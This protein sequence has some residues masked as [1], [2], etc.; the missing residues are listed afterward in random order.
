MNGAIKGMQEGTDAPAA[1]VPPSPRA[2]RRPAAFS[3]FLGDRPTATAILLCA[4]AAAALDGLQLSRPGY[5]LGRTA[6]IAVYLGSAVRLIHG[7]APYRDF[8][9]VQPPG[10]TLLLSP[11][12]LLSDLV[13]TRGALTAVRLGAILVAVANVIL[14][15]RLVRHRGPLLSLVA[16]AVMAVYPAEL[17]ALNAGLLEPLVDLFCLLGAVIIFEEGSCTLSR[18]RW[19]IGGAAVGFAAAVKLPALFPALVL[20]VM[21]LPAP[22]RRLL[23][24]AAGGV[25]GF[26]VPT[27]AFIAAAPGSF[28]RDV[29]LSQLGRSAGRA[30]VAVRLGWMALNGDRGVGAIAAAL[31]VLAVIVLGM[32]VRGR[33][34]DA[35]ERFAIASAALIA[36]AQFVPAQYFPQYAAL[37]GPYLAITLGVAADRLAARARRPRWDLR[38]V[39]VILVFLFGASAFEV[40]GSSVSDPAAAIDAVVPPGGCSISS[41]PIVLVISD[42]FVS[43]SPGCTAMVDSFGTKLAFADDPSAGVADYRAAITHADYLVLG[44]PAAAWL[45]GAYAPL[46]AYV[47][48]DFHLVRSGPEWIYI[49]DGSPVA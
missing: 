11:A 9:L 10:S 43:S 34:R 2:A 32:A 18:R 27:I 42:R 7:A 8:V 26:G 25:A 15:G 41:A 30:P 3:G 37:L 40:E 5:L 44:F 46:Q 49:R 17:Y 12:A 23:P 28:F 24:F 47:A 21:C 16:C 48:G 4:I 6:D 39:A 38:L 33:R 20:A 1:P 19:L 35:M 31:L 45:D 36:A 13:G 22:R 14:V 29:V